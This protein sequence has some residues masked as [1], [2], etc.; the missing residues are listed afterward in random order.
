MTTRDD[1]EMV[2]T[3]H[4]WRQKSGASK[5]AQPNEIT[6]AA[7]SDDLGRFFDTDIIGR[8]MA[9]AS[10][11]EELDQSDSSVA[12]MREAAAEIARLRE[13]NESLK[14]HVETYRN[15]TAGREKIYQAAREER[16]E[17]LDHLRAAGV[18][19]V[20]AANTIERLGSTETADAVRRM[21]EQML[22]VIRRAEGR[23]SCRTCGGAGEINV[24]EN[25]REPRQMASCP[26]CKAE[27]RQS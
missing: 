11:S 7:P 27:A 9:E 21:A 12:V 10:A 4:G 17:M 14:A 22:P 15:V 2:W 19:L 3:E 8:L 23:Q 25:S 13:E 16:A 1:P 24:H 20:T 18:N 5:P 6:Q 26:D